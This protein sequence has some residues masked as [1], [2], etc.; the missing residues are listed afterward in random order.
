MI[1]ASVM[2]IT[3]EILTERHLHTPLPY[4]E[5]LVESGIRTGPACSDVAQNAAVP[6]DAK[7]THLSAL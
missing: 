1:G 4:L 3:H 7:F 2:T 6:L 5:A